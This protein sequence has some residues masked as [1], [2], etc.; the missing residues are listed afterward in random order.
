ME[1][2]LGKH[3]ALWHNLKEYDPSQQLSPLATLV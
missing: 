1:E 2:N 3:N